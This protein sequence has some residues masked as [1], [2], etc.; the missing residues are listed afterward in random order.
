M[1][2]VLYNLLFF[3]H[4]TMFYN[5]IYI[6]CSISDSLAHGQDIASLPLNRGS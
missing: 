1:L 6:L 3:Y 2:F 5:I 4:F